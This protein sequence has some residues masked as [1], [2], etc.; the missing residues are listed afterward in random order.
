MTQQTDI[1]ALTAA[2]LESA[3]IVVDC[4][5]APEERRIAAISIVVPINIEARIS[6]TCYRLVSKK[7]LIA[8]A[9][10]L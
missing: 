4:S 3:Q 6:A 5:Q 7:F 2:D 8:P 10:T 9:T 1:F